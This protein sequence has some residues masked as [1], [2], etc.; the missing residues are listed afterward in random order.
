[1]EYAAS[2]AGMF[3]T[4]EW[5]IVKKPEKKEANIIASPDELSLAPVH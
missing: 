4:T 3:V 5:V 1:L 2:V